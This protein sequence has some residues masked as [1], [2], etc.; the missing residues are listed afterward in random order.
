MRRVCSEGVGPIEITR[1][2]HDIV[3]YIE[4]EQR[5]TDASLLHHLYFGRKV[6]QLNCNHF[7]N[8]L[9]VFY[10]APLL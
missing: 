4:P 10:L 5:R 6:Q 7:L 1:Q 2:M 8:P 3:Y 9:Q